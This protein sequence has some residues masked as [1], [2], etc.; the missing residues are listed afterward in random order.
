MEDEFL[1]AMYEER[2][3]PMFYE[4]PPSYYD[5]ELYDEESDWYDADAWGAENDREEGHGTN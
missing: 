2:Y 3:E 1:D 5:D 4:D